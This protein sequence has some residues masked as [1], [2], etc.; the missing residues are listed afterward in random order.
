MLVLLNHFNEKTLG[1]GVKFPWSFF[2]NGYVGVNI[3]FVISGYLITVLLMRENALTHTINLKK[4]YIRRTLRIF[5]AYYFLLL[6]YFILQLCHVLYFPPV[7]WLTSLTYTKYFH[8]TEWE[9]DHIWSLSVEEHFYLIW[10]LIFK[11]SKKN[12][13]KF[14]F[15]V[16]AI[17]PVFRVLHHVY[18]IEWMDALTLFYR[19]DAIAF[20]CLLALHEEKVK[21]FV[22][23]FI[24]KSKAFF[25][26]PLVVIMVLFAYAGQ[27]YPWPV[28]NT[29]VVAFGSK[30][31]GTVANLA[32]VY[33]LVISLYYNTAWFKFLNLPFINF[34]GKIS[35]GLYLWQQIFF[36]FHLK[37]FS[38][39]PLNICCIIVMALFS[40]YVI[41]Q[42]ILKIK[43]RYEIR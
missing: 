33:L 4:F 24:Q 18:N 43:R 14:L 12:K 34:I 26:L 19:V 20:G 9:T 40:Y 31:H 29:L 39:F 3:F 25:F 28:F 17:V 27:T 2:F 37:S 7:S 22:E 10:P 35:Y 1:F 30:T 5:P 21:L 11:F 13:N 32:I 15:F 6:F 23:K 16:I 42:P 8:R 41:E 38:N 36:S